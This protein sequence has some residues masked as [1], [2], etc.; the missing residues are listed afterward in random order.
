[1]HARQLD[2]GDRTIHLRGLHYM[3]MSDEVT[4]PNGLPYTNTDAD[5]V[6]LQENAAKAARWLG[7][8]PFAQIVD[9]RNT[10]PV[11]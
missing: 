10:P 6:W 11:I 8:L 3:L 2:L 1:M 9:N 4:K 5:W 7:Y